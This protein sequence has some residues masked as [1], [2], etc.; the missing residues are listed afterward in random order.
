MT[1]M[2]IEGM[3]NGCFNMAK[4]EGIRACR[5]YRAHLESF[6][7]KTWLEHLFGDL[8]SVKSSKKFEKI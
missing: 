5:E 7:Y 2:E 1:K 4:D 6:G 3:K 8:F